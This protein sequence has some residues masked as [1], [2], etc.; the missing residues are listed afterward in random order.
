M[1][2][3]NCLE[4]LRV[5]VGKIVELDY[6]IRVSIVEDILGA[7]RRLIDRLYIVEVYMLGEIK[8]EKKS[9]DRLRDRC[10][11]NKNFKIIVEKTKPV[12]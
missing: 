1:F 11:F 5:V 8:E 7:R 6:Y 2:E 3:R 9:V 10:I 4:G 12:S